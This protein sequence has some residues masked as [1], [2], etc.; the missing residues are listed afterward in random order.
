MEFFGD[1]KTDKELFK[2]K[3]IF[4]YQECVFHIIAQH[5]TSRQS[6]LFGAPITD[7]TLPGPDSISSGDGAFE[8]VD[9]DFNF[10]ESKLNWRYMRFYRDG[11]VRHGTFETEQAKPA[12]TA[13]V[14]VL[15]FGRPEEQAVLA[16]R[17]VDNSGNPIANLQLFVR[18][19]PIS[20]VNMVKHLE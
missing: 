9:P 10:G 19:V 14:H 6:V 13:R 2:N 4:P 17:A 12:G 5:Y 3:Y 16:G 1:F 18:D 11:S 8:I 7:I 15:P 20:R